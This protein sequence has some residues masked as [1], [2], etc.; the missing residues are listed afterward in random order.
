MIRRNISQIIDNKRKIDFKKELEAASKG[1]IMIHDPNLLMKMI[2]RMIV[3]KVKIKHAGMI[4]F[5]PDSGSYVLSIS[6]GEMGV[7]IPPG[8]TRFTDESPIIKILNQKEY[9]PITSYGNAVL[10]DDINKL[11]WREGVIEGK[12]NSAFKGLLHLVEEQ[13]N[14]LNAVACVPAQHHGKLMAVLLLGAKCDGTKY[15]K[16]EL[17]FFSALASDTAMAIQNAQLFDHLKKEAEKNRRQ[18]VQTII[19]LSST[20]EAKDAYTHGHTERVTNYS[21]AI[22]RQMAANGSIEFPEKFFE[23]LHIGALLHDIGK[24]GVPEA[25]LH[26][27]SSLTD[28]E[29]AQVKLHATG[30]ADIIRPLGL[31]QESVDGIKHH[32]E[33]YDGYGYPH[34]LKS[35]EIPIAASIIAV[36][37]AYDA[38]I[39]DR[40]YRKALTKSAAI[41]EIINCSG[42]QFDPVPVRAIIELNKIGIV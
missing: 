38:M 1:M 35:N 16:D 17:D 39:T 33:R 24:I 5:D 4:L 30:G 21:L 2:I 10:L 3:R 40:P 34:G 7:K 22:A 36:A 13:M 18:F 8:F 27:N 12:A 20:I 19:V 29:Y 32:H 25:I 15:K 9:R 41:N 11:V 23:N 26:K 37:D 31:P 14:M 28:E 6:R 42:L